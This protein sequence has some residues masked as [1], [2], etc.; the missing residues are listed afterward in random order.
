MLRS[1]AIIFVVQPLLFVAFSFII[2]LLFFFQKSSVKCG[3]IECLKDLRAQC[4]ASNSAS[5]S[6]K[7]TISEKLRI[8][9]TFEPFTPQGD[10]LIDLLILQPKKGLS[11][12]QWSSILVIWAPKSRKF[13]NKK[14]FDSTS[15]TSPRH[16]PSSQSFTEGKKEI[17]A[18]EFYTQ[19]SLFL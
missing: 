12:H 3:A 9:L 13:V 17:L 1:S 18:F 7:K 16:I 8:I 4:C 19:D 11:L 5:K 6:P 10:L 15:Y 14:R 2:C